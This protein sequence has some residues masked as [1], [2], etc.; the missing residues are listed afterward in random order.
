LPLSNTVYPFFQCG[1]NW[2][3]THW[4]YVLN[5]GNGNHPE[6]LGNLWNIFQNSEDHS[7]VFD[8]ILR[9]HLCLYSALCGHKG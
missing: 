3:W 4:L 5:H 8:I 6:I 9:F 7:G 1:V 2:S